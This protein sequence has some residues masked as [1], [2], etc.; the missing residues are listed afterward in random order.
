MTCDEMSQAL[1]ESPRYPAATLARDALPS[2][3]GLYA[4]HDIESGKMVYIGRATGKSG[5]RRRIRQHLNPKYLERRASKSYRADAFQ[6]SCAV[7]ID[8]RPAAIDKSM[9][10]KKIGRHHRLAPGQSTVD[11]ILDKLEISWLVLPNET[12]DQI[13]ACEAALIRTWCPQ[14]NGGSPK[15]PAAS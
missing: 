5:L 14:F 1:R 9:L 15:R 3:W 10:R 12:D 11:Y 13:H 7:L 6:R 2:E 8:G 4:W